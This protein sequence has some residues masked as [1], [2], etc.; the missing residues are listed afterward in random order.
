MFRK[1][2]APLATTKSRQKIVEKKNHTHLYAGEYLATP[3][4]SMKITWKKTCN[5]HF[6][7][8]IDGEK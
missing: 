1:K 8:K 2:N 4:I 6:C 5:K 3:A 7:H